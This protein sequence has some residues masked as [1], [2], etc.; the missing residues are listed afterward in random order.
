V[1][2]AGCHA[3]LAH[4]LRHLPAVVRDHAGRAGPSR[5]LDVYDVVAVWVRDVLELYPVPTARPARLD[6][7]LAAPTRGPVTWR[8]RPLGADGPGLADALSDAVRELCG[9]LDRHL[10]WVEAQPWAG[11]LAAELG[12]L[13]AP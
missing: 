11:R 2:C 1:L 12:G 6:A 3:R 10:P 8:H 7:A 4:A 13:A 5:A 9:W